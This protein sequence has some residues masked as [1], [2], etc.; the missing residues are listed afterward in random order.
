M[1]GILYLLHFISDLVSILVSENDV[2]HLDSSINPR[3]ITPL[4]SIENGKEPLIMPISGLHL[5][6]Y[7]YYYAIFLL[8]SHNANNPDCCISGI[9]IQAN[10]R[11]APC[12]YVMLANLSAPMNFMTMST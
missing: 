4:T 3:L 5:Y 7:Y 9:I 2:L 12:M 8:I 11:P 10:C 1:K 6:Y